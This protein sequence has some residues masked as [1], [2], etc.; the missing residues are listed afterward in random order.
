MSKVIW[1]SGIS[2]AGKSTLAQRLAEDFAK[3]ELVHELMDGNV[4]RDFFDNDLGFT[5]ADR[6]SATKRIVFG[7]YL[8]SRHNVFSIVT[9]ISGSEAVRKF[10]RDK[11]GGALIHI[12][13]RAT[14]EVVR[15]RDVWG[16]Y[17]RHDG[18]DESNIVGIDEIFEE[19]ESP[20]LVVETTTD[21]V[22]QSYQKVKSFLNIE[23]NINF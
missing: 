8:L 5:N 6:V 20:D 17:K 16:H 21:S 14:L 10:T 1:F 15:E 9:N 4:V 3:A 7:S 2:G 22:E 19:P 18:G 13:V 12:F 11:L 23:C